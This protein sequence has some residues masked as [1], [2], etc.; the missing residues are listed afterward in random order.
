MTEGTGR[1]T[2]LTSDSHSMLV[3]IRP[4]DKHL[5]RIVEALAEQEDISMS[6]WLRK[7]VEHYIICSQFHERKQDTN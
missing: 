5:R 1:Q 6:E 2:S 4:Q 3:N 7:A